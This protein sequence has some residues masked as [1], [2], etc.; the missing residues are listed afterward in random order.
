MSDLGYA[1]MQL[2]L[3]L[4][5]CKKMKA[6]NDI[7]GLQRMVPIAQ[8][9]AITLANFDSNWREHNVRSKKYVEKLGILFDEFSS[10]HNSE[11]KKYSL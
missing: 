10:Y 3:D 8:F 7:E 1:K 6:N 2:V 9:R 4:V 5:E 11:L